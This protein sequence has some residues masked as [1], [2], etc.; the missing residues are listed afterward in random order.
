MTNPSPTLLPVHNSARKWAAI[1]FFQSF[2]LSRLRAPGRDILRVATV[3]SLAELCRAYSSS[4]S[5]S[6]DEL[7][8]VGLSD[9]SSCWRPSIVRKVLIGH[10]HRWHLS[11]LSYE[12][13]PQVTLGEATGHRKFYNLI[14][15]SQRAKLF[16][17][18]FKHFYVACLASVESIRFNSFIFAKYGLFGMV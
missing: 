9:W 13:N 17:Q 12:W 5:L 3:L 2:M 16:E 15:I 11:T 8:A 7:R 10:N 6:K 4:I 14:R 1:N 18:F